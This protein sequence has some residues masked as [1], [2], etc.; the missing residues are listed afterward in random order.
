MVSASPTVLDAIPEEPAVT[1]HLDCGT[2]VVI[3][4]GLITPA[5]AA[6]S[7]LIWACNQKL[8]CEHQVS[9]SG[10]LTQVEPREALAW[11]TADWA[12]R[13]SLH[14]RL[15]DFDDVDRNLSHSAPGWI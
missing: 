11:R 2:G 3:V 4:G 9:P 10:E 6:R 13:D 8:D 5:V 14:T 15:L 1:F 12:G 7:A